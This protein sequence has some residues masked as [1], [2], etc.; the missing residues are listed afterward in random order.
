LL[1]R[2]DLLLSV[3]RFIAVNIYGKTPF[4]AS[5]ALLLKRNSLRNAS[6]LL[7]FKVTLPTSGQSTVGWGRLLDL[8]PGLQVNSL[9][10]LPMSHPSSQ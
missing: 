1:H 3:K 5:S 8:N 7:L 9:V 2:Y 10:S 6:S 4:N